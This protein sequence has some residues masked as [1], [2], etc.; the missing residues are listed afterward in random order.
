MK[1]INR[2]K[3]LKGVCYDIRG[4]VLEQAK[5]LEDDGHKILKLNI[6]NPAP[7]GFDAPDDILKDVIHNLPTAQ[8]YGPSNGIYPAKVAIHQY[9]QTFGLLNT[10]VD[11][12]YIG[13]GVSE[14]IVMAMQALLN[15]GDEVLLP[16]P[17]YPLWTAAVNLAGGKP[18]HYIC[19]ESADWQPDIADIKAKVT[20]KTR[21]IVVI[22]PNNPTGA[23]YSKEILESITSI[24]REHNLII[25]SDEIYDK[26]LYDQS[27]HTPIAT[28]SDDVFCATFSGLSKNYRVAGFRAGW[29][30]LT[31]PKRHAAD[32]I[33]GLDMLSSMRL[34]ANVPSQHAIQTALGGY[35]SIHDLTKAEGR[36]YQQMEIAYQ[37]VNDIPGLSCTRPKGA[38]YLFPKIDVKKFNIKNDEQL[39]LDFLLEK[40]VLLVHGTAFNWKQP[41]HFR[42]VFLPYKDELK[43]AILSLGDFLDGYRQR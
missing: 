17:D 25:Y 14:L 7:F 22:N 4:T 23:V 5:R 15:D 37:L 16:S 28:L 41:D 29:M 8:G 2:S 6:G 33:R 32:Y 31:G 43:T 35:Q 11:D 27:I 26:I 3:K 42:I 18:V 24:A 34:C 19:D 20:N 40:H 13:N 10:S 1:R 39:V 12:I 38:M 9:Y 21:A 30:F 36:L